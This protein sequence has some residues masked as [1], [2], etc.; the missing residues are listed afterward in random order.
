MA[1]DVQPIQGEDPTVLE[2]RQNFQ[3]IAWFKDLP[4]DDEK[5]VKNI[6][7][8]LNRNT[9]KLTPLEL[10]HA[11]F[12]GRFLRAAEAAALKVEAELPNNFPRIV[13]QSRK[14]MKD[15]EMGARPRRR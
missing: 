9:A 1:V 3:N 11:R 5:I 12:E 7:D 6:F 14:Q 2:R 10:R 13:G 8:R 4:A 15:V